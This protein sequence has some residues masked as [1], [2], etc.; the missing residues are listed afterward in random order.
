MVR[1]VTGR[2]FRQE[3]FSKP[4]EEILS[5]GTDE[6]RFFIEEG[7][8]PSKDETIIIFRYFSEENQLDL[9]TEVLA[10]PATTLKEMYCN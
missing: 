1:V 9:S 2:F 10:T 8:I 6:I 7:V 5:K 4:C 3:D